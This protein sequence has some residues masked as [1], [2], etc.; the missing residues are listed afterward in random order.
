MSESEIIKFPYESPTEY[1]EFRGMIYDVTFNNYLTRHG[2]PFDRGSADSYYR[3]PSVPHYWPE[4]TGHGE[5][6]MEKDMTE[7][8]VVEYL[9]GFEYNE[10][11]V[12]DYKDWG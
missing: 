1:F 5:Q 7:D 8:E 2:G 11:I 6:V 3:R 10:T 12:Q 9:A 4:G